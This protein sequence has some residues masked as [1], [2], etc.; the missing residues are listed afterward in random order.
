[1]NFRKTVDRLN[2][3]ETRMVK[4]ITNLF[5]KHTEIEYKKN[6]NYKIEEYFDKLEDENLNLKHEVSILRD[7]LRILCDTKMIDESFN[8]DVM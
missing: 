6:E 2:L 1:M 8:N 3:L 7:K 4:S 5:Q